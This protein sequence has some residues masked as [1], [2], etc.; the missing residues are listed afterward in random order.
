MMINTEGVIIRMSCE[1][2]SVLSRVTSGVKLM[3]LDGDDVVV[4]VAKVR[5]SVP[6]NDYDET[7]DAEESA[8][9]SSEDDADGGN[10]SEDVNTGEGE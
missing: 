1:N 7:D 10:A 3:R 9:A 8:D 5:E 6:K 4:S 2:I